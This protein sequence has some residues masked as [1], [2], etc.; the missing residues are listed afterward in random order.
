M[1]AQLVAAVFIKF[2]VVALGLFVGGLWVN[3]FNDSV[4]AA[5]PAGYLGLQI[6]EY[7][8]VVAGL[9]VDTNGHGGI[10]YAQGMGHKG[11]CLKA[12]ELFVELLGHGIIWH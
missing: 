12:P 10:V 6:D 3:N 8:V 5:K 1:E 11:G 9:F 4:K 2:K 7:L